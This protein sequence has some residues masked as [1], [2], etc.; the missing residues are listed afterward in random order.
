VSA[1]PA[2]IDKLVIMMGLIGPKVLDGPPVGVWPDEDCIIVGWTR[3]VGAP[4]AGGGGVNVGNVEGFVSTDQENF[5]ISCMISVVGGDLTLPALR[6][7]AVGYYDTA[8]AA[9]RHD[10]TLLGSVAHAQVLTASMR[11][12]LNQEAGGAVEMYFDVS[13]AAFV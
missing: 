9:I 4:T 13:C 3:D 5:S 11:Q 2:A 12:Y 10:R 7:R 1:I 8:T 6:N